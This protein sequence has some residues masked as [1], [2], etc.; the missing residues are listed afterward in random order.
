MKVYRES[1]RNPIQERVALLRKILDRLNPYFDSQSKIT[2]KSTAKVSQEVELLRAIQNSA[3]YL[4]VNESTFFGD[5]L[6]LTPLVKFDHGLEHAVDMGWVHG[7]HRVHEVVLD[8][9]DTR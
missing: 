2:V 1:P 7:V 6:G 8:I 9:R 3:F 5:H 4:D